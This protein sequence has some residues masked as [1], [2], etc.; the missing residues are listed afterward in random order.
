MRCTSLILALTLAATT[1]DLLLAAAPAFATPG[2][3]PF[4]PQGAP[5]GSGSFAAKPVP[6]IRSGFNPPAA[7][8]T[9]KG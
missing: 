4:A 1:A 7:V 6:Q 8:R 3:K 5:R 2:K 9:F